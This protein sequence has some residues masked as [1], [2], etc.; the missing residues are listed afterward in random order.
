MFFAILIKFYD[1]NYLQLIESDD[2]KLRGPYLGRLELHRVM[3]KNQFNPDD[4]MGDYLELLVEYFRF[5]GDRG[6]CTN[7]IAL[8]LD[9]LNP[10]RYSEL[11]TRLIQECGISPSTLPQDVRFNFI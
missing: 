6:C 3:K 2:K 5:F 4:L 7:D 10:K 8:F 11:A 9:N 1:N